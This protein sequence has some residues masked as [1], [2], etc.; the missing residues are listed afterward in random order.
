MAGRV[1][2]ALDV[3]SHLGTPQ[4]DAHVAVIFNLPF[5]RP[6]PKP[7]SHVSPEAN[8]PSCFIKPRLQRRP[9]FEGRILVPL[10]GRR[11]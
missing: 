8:F 9:E 4:E 11:R 2:C 10:E 7:H 3:P 6:R 1:A 5:Q